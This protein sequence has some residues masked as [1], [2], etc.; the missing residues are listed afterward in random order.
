MKLHHVYQFALYVLLGAGVASAQ[1]KPP[2][3]PPGGSPGLHGPGGLGGPGGNNGIPGDSPGNGSGSASASQSHAVPHFGPVGR[4]WDDKSVVR[5]IGL[6]SDQQR[7]MDTVFNSNKPAILSAYKTF[8][9]EQAKLDAL[10]KQTQ[11]DQT[12]MFSAIDAVSQAK[13]SLEKA[14]TQM[15]LQ[16]RQQMT[17]DQIGKLERLQ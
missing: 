8:L 11:V 1:G 17:T 15:L 7:K 4:W 14:N 12:R 10:S 2:G 6:S 16:I 5:A 13:A 3:P 9:S